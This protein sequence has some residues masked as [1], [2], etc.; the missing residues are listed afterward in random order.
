MAKKQSKQTQ[1]SASRG[2]QAFIKLYPDYGSVGS[3]LKAIGVKSRNTFYNW[4]KD[5][6]F[7][8]I[9]ENEL[10]P[11]RRDEVVSL[12]YRVATGRLG[13]HVKTVT[14]KNGTETTEEVPNEI[15]QTQLTAAFGS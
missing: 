15:P 11:N 3:T 13:T 9:Y 4:L 12:V 2:K 1:E 7:R 10:L 14:Y 8:G 5:D 6:R